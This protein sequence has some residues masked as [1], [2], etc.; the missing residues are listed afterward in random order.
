MKSKI[1][2]RKQLLVATVSLALCAAVFINWY[3]T[4]PK[5]LSEENKPEVSENVNLGEAQYVN[6]SKNID[7]SDYFGV[8]RLNRTKAHDSSKER[9]QE[10]ISDEKVD[11][12]TKSMAREKLVSMSAGIKTEADI[13]NLITA[14]LNKS[15]LVTLDADSIEIV[16]PKG[17]INSE[18]LI[19]V[20]D[21]VI[22]KTSFSSE[23]ITI[24]ELK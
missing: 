13:E 2:G 19:K 23:N 17:T 12:E 7:E 15:C 22:S 18:I 3:Y 16:L 21:I 5:G 11:D 4:K 24:I 14:Q 9:L 1:I 6:G 10:I 8:A 20:K